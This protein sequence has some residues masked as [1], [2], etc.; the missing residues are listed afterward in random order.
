MLF[1]TWIHDSLAHV[2]HYFGDFSLALFRFRDVYKSSYIGTTQTQFAVAPWHSLCK[3]TSSPVQ[4]FV[5]F[6]VYL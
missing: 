5:T 2:D 3:F 1:I 6:L 4:S